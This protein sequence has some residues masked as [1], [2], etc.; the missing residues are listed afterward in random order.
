MTC[1]DVHIQFDMEITYIACRF[2]A[3]AVTRSFV[4]LSFVVFR[5]SLLTAQREEHYNHFY[6]FY[7]TILTFPEL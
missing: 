5:S 4:L 1:A 3:E 7:E 2:V 6:A